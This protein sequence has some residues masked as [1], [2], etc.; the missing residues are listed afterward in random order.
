[1][2]FIS[3]LL[4][5]AG[6]VV[7]GLSTPHDSFTTVGQVEQDLTNVEQSTLAVK[8]ALVSLSDTAPTQP[9]LKVTFLATLIYILFM[10]SPFQLVV[11]GSYNVTVA[12]EQ[13]SKDVAVCTF[14]CLSQTDISI[15][16]EA[17]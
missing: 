7:A 8:A 14:I 15:S 17:S 12:I 4:V 1:M 11:A 3:T 6:L 2:R 16:V 10:L 9:Q 13:C 5:V